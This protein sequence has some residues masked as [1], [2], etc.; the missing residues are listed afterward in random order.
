VFIQKAVNSLGSTAVVACNT[1]S[2]NLGGF[3]YTSMNAIYQACISFTSQNNGAKNY[4]RCKQVLYTC[5][6]SVTVVGFAIGGIVVLC[7]KPLLGIYVTSNEALKQGLIRL[8]IVGSTYFLCGIADVIVGGM[9]GLGKSIAPM[10]ISIVGICGFRIYW[11]YT[12]F[13]RNHEARVLYYSYPLSWF[14]TS[15][16]NIVAYIIIYKMVTKPKDNLQ[17]QEI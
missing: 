15:I 13:E 12:A 11:I 2:S 1:A 14:F 17:I 9:R 16:M 3:I 10:V 5:V 8:R 7:G 4:K 6:L